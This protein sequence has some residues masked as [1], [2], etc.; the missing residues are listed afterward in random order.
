MPYNDGME[1]IRSLEKSHP[2]VIVFAI[3]GVMNTDFDCLQVAKALGAEE[4]F[5]KPI[6]LPELEIGMEKWGVPASYQT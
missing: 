4:V 6:M 1:V 2:E 3:S 5:R